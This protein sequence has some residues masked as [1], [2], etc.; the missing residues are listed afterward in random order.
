RV[1]LAFNT[2]CTFLS[3]DGFLGDSQSQTRALNVAN[4]A[5]SM[6]GFKEPFLIFGGDTDPLIFDM[7]NGSF[8]VAAQINHNG[9]AFWRVL[10]SVGEQV[11]HDLPQQLFVHHGS[12]AHATRVEYKVVR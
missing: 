7:D 4:I 3:F 9:A 8:F 5:P 6:E 12:L 11:I 2:D 10:A 1:Q